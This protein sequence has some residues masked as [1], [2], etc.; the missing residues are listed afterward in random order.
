VVAVVTRE[1]AVRAVCRVRRL[2]TKPLPENGLPGKGLPGRGL[3]GNGLLIAENSC[4]KRWKGGPAEVVG[5]TALFIS[6]TLIL[7]GSI[8]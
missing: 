4:A 6:M 7:G 8:E 3:L 2:A 1:D 5:A